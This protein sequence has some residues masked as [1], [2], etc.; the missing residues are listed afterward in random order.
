MYSIQN[1]K[2]DNQTFVEVSKKNQGFYALI[3]LTDGCRLQEFS[4][5]KVP[6]IKELSTF[7]YS[8]SYASAL[9]FPFVSR[10]AKGKFNYR[11]SN[12]QL[13]CN[14]PGGANALHGLI[15]NKVFEFLSSEMND[16]RLDLFFSY[17]KTQKSKGFP[18]EYEVK[19]C[20]SFTE[21]SVNVSLKVTNT[22]DDDF[23]FTIGW[24]PYF[25]VANTSEA[26]LEFSSHQKVIFNE[27]LIT[28]ELVDHST[29]NRLSLH[30]QS[31]DDCFLL[32]KDLV[33]LYTSDY[34][35][36]ISSEPLEYLQ[37]YTPPNL[38]LV[39]IEPMIGLSNSLNNDIGKQELKAGEQFQTTWK[40]RMNTTTYE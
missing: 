16:G 18:F 5:H 22:G 38:P 29:P 1:F 4:L 25:Y 33:T 21:D 17:R 24:H 6:I 10:T 14:E 23:P 31:F 28:K 36:E 9:L 34:T 8:A 7:P 40:V 35:I 37:I 13:E 15:Y 39:A 3:N 12:Y 26:W 30:Q 2:R 27:H 20:Y 32:N 19:V 11:D